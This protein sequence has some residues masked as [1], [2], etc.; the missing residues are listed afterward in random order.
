MG[1]DNVLKCIPA[2]ESSTSCRVVSFLYSS[3]L[4][5]STLV[6]AHLAL[7]YTASIFRLTSL[8]NGL[9]VALRG[10]W[11]AGSLMAALE[12]YSDH[13]TV[14]ASHTCYR[15]NA[16][17]TFITTTGLSLAVCIVA[18]LSGLVA[19][20]FRMGFAVQ[21]RLHL[22]VQMFVLAFLISSLPNFCRV[23]SDSNYDPSAFWGKSWAKTTALALFNLSGFVN[24]LVYASPSGY[25][26]RASRP[27]VRPTVGNDNEH[28]PKAVGSFHVGMGHVD[29]S[30]L[31]VPP[32]SAGTA[33]NSDVIVAD[34]P[35]EN[36]FFDF[37]DL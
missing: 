24:F 29:V 36:A 7:S 12:V 16:D 21:R 28:T 27:P 11:C 3:G 9:G 32:S 10:V 19:V 22:R 35:S 23:M 14:N 33:T 13:L 25:L 34:G 26:R 37:F 17:Y 4:L 6:E 31:E 2:L 18:Y 1:A 5:T 8:L 30:F 20:H 15:E